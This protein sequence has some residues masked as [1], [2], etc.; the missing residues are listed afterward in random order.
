MGAVVNYFPVPGSQ[1]SA[2]LAWL[3]QMA[4]FVQAKDPTLTRVVFRSSCNTMADFDLATA[5]NS[6]T[7]GLVAIPGSNFL[8][9]RVST[10]TSASSLQQVS[11]RNL[12]VPAAASTFT[13]II[14][15]CRTSKFAVCTRTIINAINV[16]AQNICCN[17]TDQASADSYLG[18]VGATS[19][20]NFCMKI[21]AAAA[22]DTG[23][24][25]GTLGTTE[26]D[27]I[28]IGDTTNINAYIDLATTAV[29]TGA[30]NTA[31]NAAG[32][33]NTYAVNGVTATNV[34]HD[35]LQWAAFAV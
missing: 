33:V 25:I 28:I 1:E 30:Q 15:N 17:M 31:A 32:H 5:V 8:K 4:A 21:G 6:A 12:A 14:A 34:S 29:A 10:G 22:I 19:Q 13:P 18:T 11:Q 2:S 16:T 26:H 7:S 27:L 23:V 3:T 20:V 35:T 24:A 9:L